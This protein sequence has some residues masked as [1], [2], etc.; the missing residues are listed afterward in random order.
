MRAKKPSVKQ[1]KAGPYAPP[2]ATKL[3]QLSAPGKI[4]KSTTNQSQAIK[5][6]NAASLESDGSK[7]GDVVP[8]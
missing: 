3:S 1:P 7:T 4:A 6:P 8:Q 2:S 5:V